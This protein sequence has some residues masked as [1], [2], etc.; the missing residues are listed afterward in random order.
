[1]PEKMTAIIIRNVPE[2]VRRGIKVAA[3]AEGK[4]MQALVIELMMR[5]IAK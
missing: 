4:T 5:H 1:M 2:S 3:A